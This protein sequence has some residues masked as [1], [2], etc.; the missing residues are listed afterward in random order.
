MRKFNK[1]I[2]L[3][4]NIKY[5]QRTG[6]CVCGLKITGKGKGLEGGFKAL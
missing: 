1:I 6:L 2:L 4:T 5:R 3:Q